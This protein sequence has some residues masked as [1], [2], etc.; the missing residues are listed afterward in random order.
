[1]VLGAPQ[2]PR[3]LVG[4]EGGIAGTLEAVEYLADLGRS[5]AGQQLER[6]AGLR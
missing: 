4:R 2:I 1:L 6:R 5:I 3:I